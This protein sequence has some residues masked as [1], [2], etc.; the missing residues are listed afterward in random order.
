[1]LLSFKQL[2]V[3]AADLGGDREGQTVCRPPSAV[4]RAADC[5]GREGSKLEG[6]DGGT[7]KKTWQGNPVG[8][9][10]KVW[11]EGLSTPYII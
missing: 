10:Y 6:L 5:S 11:R 1:M 9:T 2:A 8:K 3:W 7:A 4:H